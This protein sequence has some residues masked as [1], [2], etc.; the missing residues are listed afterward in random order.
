MAQLSKRL[1]FN[2]TNTFTGD[3]KLLAHFFQRSRLAVVD[4]VAQAKHLFFSG[5]K[6]IQHVEQLFDYGSAVR[7]V[8]YTTNAIE[9][10]NSSFRKVTK[11]GSFP[12]ENAVF[13]ILYLRVTELQ[14]KWDGGH[15]QNWS[16]V[17]N[18]LMVNEKF[19]ERINKYLA[20]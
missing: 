6:R 18:Q 1:R 16:M 14:K 11:K 9:A 3:V 5:R 15:Y 2:L 17:L 19:T 13:K 10:V 4:T 7:K 20:Y 8:M 12:N